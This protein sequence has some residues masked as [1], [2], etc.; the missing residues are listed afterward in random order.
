MTGPSPSLPAE[1]ERDTVVVASLT[2]RMFRVWGGGGERNGKPEANGHKMIAPHHLKMLADS[3]IP[4]EHAEAR[5]YETITDSGRLA[6]LK[7]VKAARGCVPGLLLP[8][9]RPDGSTWGYQYRPDTPR[10]R[11]G[12]P[13]KYETPYQQ[14][15]GLDIPPG[16]EDLLENPEVPLWVTEGTKKA[17]CAAQYGLCCIALSGV[18]NWRGTNDMGGKTAV[19]DWN[20]I[21]LNGRRVI[22]AFDGDVARKNSAAKA[23]SELAS[24]L[25]FKGASVEYL[26]LPDTKPKTGLDDFLCDDTNTA[27]DLWK[28]VKPDPPP[29][30]DEDDDWYTVLDDDEPD[31]EPLQ[32]ISLAECHAVFHKWLGKDYDT[33]ALNAMLAAAAVERFE[34][35]SDPIWLLLISGPGNAKTETVQALDGAGAIVTSSIVSDAALLS[36]TPARERSR[37]AT[38][39]LLRKIGPRGLLVIKDFTSIL[40][41]DRTLRAKVLAALRE[42]YDGRWTREVGSGGGASLSWRG[43]IATIGAVTTAWDTHQAVVSVMGDRFV[44]VRVDSTVHRQD[45]G[46]KAIGNTGYEAE[47]RAELAAAA[48]GVIA[49]MN[50]SPIAL[51]TKMT[52]RLL[53][54][55]DLVTRARTGVERDYKGDVID[56]H[57]P[58][59]PTRFAKQLAQ[60]VRGGVAIGLSRREAMRLAIRCARDSVPPLRLEILNYLAKCPNSTTTDVRKGI[61][62]PRNTVDRELQALH[63]LGLVTVNEVE[64]EQRSRWYYRLAEG[65]RPRILRPGQRTDE[66]DD[67]RLVPE[68]L[69]LEPWAETLKFITGK[70]TPQH[71]TQERAK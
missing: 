15:N 35:N 48:G 25:R 37:G 34:D 31:A 65:V 24:Y 22:L 46:R 18:W 19:A 61:D 13:V 26:H 69:P 30:P 14:R 40:S 2:R 67:A 53:G 8:M 9:L 32:P 60:V 62:K 70:V 11:E 47:M 56:A 71:P 43:R 59:M 7:I 20:E 42:I 16:I 55:A 5:G 66:H 45:A 10:L 36:G 54:V 57:A 39:G 12:K 21:P 63:M 58:E 29:V 17:D 64:R 38:G 50:T 27:A 68:K 49:G 44:L 3:G 51:N 28:L 4:L 1:P 23:L 33:D 52:E 41:M 6:T